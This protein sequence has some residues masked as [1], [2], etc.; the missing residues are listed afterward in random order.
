MKRRK[1]DKRR[2][3]EHLLYGSEDLTS[4]QDPSYYATK[5]PLAFSAHEGSRN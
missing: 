5:N 4:S 3:D 2:T 1:V